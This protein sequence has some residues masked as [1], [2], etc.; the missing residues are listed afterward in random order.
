[1][2]SSL[3]SNRRNARN[4]NH[5]EEIRSQA[6]SIGDSVRAMAVTAGEAAGETL[7]PIENYVREKPIKSMLIAAG[8]GALVGMFLLRR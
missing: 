5:M 3:K 7:G 2:S 4:H 8:A 6:V 1:M